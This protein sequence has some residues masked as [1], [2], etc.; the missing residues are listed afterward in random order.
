VV[1]TLSSFLALGFAAGPA[2]LGVVA[3]QF[4]YDGTFLAAAAVAVAG[5]VLLWRRGAGLARIYTP[6]AA[7]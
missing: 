7:T 2:G 4:G 1:G 5:L 3:R 6:S